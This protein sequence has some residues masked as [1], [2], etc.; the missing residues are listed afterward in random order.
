MAVVLMQKRDQLEKPIAFFSRTIRDATLQYNIME[1][2]ALALVKALKDFIAY[3]LHSHTIACVPN[4]AV[5]DVLIQTNPEQKEGSGL[6][7]C[8]NMI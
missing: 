1:K 7:Q 3:I 4:A 8:W 5:K 2:W 6:Q